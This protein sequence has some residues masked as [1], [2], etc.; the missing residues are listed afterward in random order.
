MERYAR[1]TI[2]PELGAEGQKRLGEASVLCIG[3]GGLGSPALQYLVAAGIGKIGIMDDDCVELTNLQRQVLF[4]ED[5]QGKSK[6]G[7]ARKRLETLNSTVEIS[8]Y[9]ERFSVANAESFLHK[10]TIV[11]DGTDNF[12]SKFLINDACVKYGR[13]LVYGSILGFEAQASVFWAVHGP[14]YRCLYPKEPSG[15]IPNCAEAGVIGAMAGIAGPVQALEAIKMALGLEWCAAHN[16]KPLLGRL[17]LLDARSMQTRSLTIPANPE[18][19]VCS[20]PRDTIRLKETEI[21]CSRSPHSVSADEALELLDKAVFIDVRETHELASGKIPHALH[22]PLRILL[23]DSNVVNIIPQDRPIVV[24]CQHGMRSL[25]G[26]SY[27]QEKGFAASS[28]EGGIVRWQ[29]SL[30]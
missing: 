24:Y 11:V 7:T 14:C 25:K 18:C 21:A 5:D 3:A 26:A 22:I 4:R 20:K 27:L 8:S 30:V 13:P 16:L 15:Y 12:S 29:G 6:A 17:W 19:P 23:E 28:L 1:Q 10:Y 9:N 2:L